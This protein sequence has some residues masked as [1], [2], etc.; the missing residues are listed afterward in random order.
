MDQTGTRSDEYTRRLATKEGAWWKHLLDVQAPYRRNLRR[1]NL[2][3]TLDIGCGLGRN[4]LHI[5]GNGVGIDH[6]SSSVEVARSRGLTAY[7]TD[8]FEGSEFNKPDTFDAILVAHVVEHMSEKEAIELLA[9][10]VPLLKPN[11]KVVLITPQERGFN[12]DP[13]HVQ[14]MDFAALRKI[15]ERA[16]LSPVIEYSFPLPRFAGRFFTHNEFVSLSRKQAESPAH[17]ESHS[18]QI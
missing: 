10:Y 17:S 6:N 12:S 2:G 11:G 4:L 14:F 5:N 8:E 7:E 16:G 15:S 18:G 13:T 1:L 9:K 3:F